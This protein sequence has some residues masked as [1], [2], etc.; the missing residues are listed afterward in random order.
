M[1]S[2]GSIF[3]RKSDDDPDRARPF[4]GRVLIKGAPDKS[5]EIGFIRRTDMKPMDWTS[6]LRAWA[7]EPE[8]TVEE[9][10]AALERER[11]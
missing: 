11:P 1:S 2:F 3:G 6:T 7:Q 4:G 5:E 9:R 10:L 8:P